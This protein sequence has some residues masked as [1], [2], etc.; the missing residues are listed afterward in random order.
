MSVLEISEQNIYLATQRG[1]LT[2]SQ[3]G[4]EKERIALDYLSAIICKAH[5][6]SYSQN[7][8][9]KLAKRNIPIIITDSSFMPVAIMQPLAVYHA[10]VQPLSAQIQAGEGLNNQLWQ[11]IIQCKIRMQAAVLNRLNIFHH[12]FSSLVE[13]VNAGDSRNI[14]AQAAR[15]YW[16]WL[17][18]ESFRRHQ[19]GAAPNGLLNYGYTILRSALA[20]EV[21]ATGLHPTIGIHHK[22]PQNAYCLVDD[23]LEPY[24]PLVDLRAHQAACRGD[25]EVTS[26]NKRTMASLLDERLRIATQWYSVADSIRFLCQSLSKAYVEQ[27]TRL[28]LPKANIQKIK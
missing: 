2:L 21:C 6:L 11:K 14:E 1:F 12:D 28:K 3:S 16:Q 22:H 10:P 15:K 26:E 8:L 18:G 19:H 24:R 7:L 13:Q 17:F 27:I 5:G 25:G 4:I 20:R 9:V 23:L